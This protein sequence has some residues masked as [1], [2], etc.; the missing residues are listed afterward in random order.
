MSSKR[1]R[2]GVVDS[3]GTLLP[4]IAGRPWNAR[5]IPHPILRH[6]AR[7]LG[8]T[9]RHENEWTDNLREPTTRLVR[10]LGERT[11]LLSG[12]RDMIPARAPVCRLSR[13]VGARS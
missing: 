11:T 6:N 2:G 1:S 12:V 7:M 10:A 4:I 3:A 5:R 13:E 8:R 9:F